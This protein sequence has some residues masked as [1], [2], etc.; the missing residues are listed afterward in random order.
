VPT[1]SPTASPTPAETGAA[2]EENGG[3]WW[4]LLIPV[5]AVAA[6]VGLLLRRGAQARR[7]YRARLATAEGEVGWFARDLIPQ[8]RGSGT[9]AAVSG[10]WAVAAPRVA[11]LDDELSELVTTAPREEERARASALRDA[12][13]NA[14]DRVTAVAG[15][16]D[17][18]TQWALD[19][20]D[21]QAPLLAVLVPPTEG[22]QAPP[23][24]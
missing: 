19:L 3:D 9:L 18:A 22:R 14:R 4:W 6:I 10:G 23:T 1:T 8:L 21:A 20:A 12:V 16:G 24:A 5:L 7:A 15:A 13:R 17:G 11:S 2:E